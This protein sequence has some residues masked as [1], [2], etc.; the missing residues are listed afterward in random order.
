MD[1]HDREGHF[2]EVRLASI[3]EKLIGLPRERQVFICEVL[4]SFLR[5]E[6]QKDRWL[7]DPT[8][9]GKVEELA[10]LVQV[11]PAD[12]QDVLIRMLEIMAEQF[13]EGLDN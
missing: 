4:E 2:V 11:Q 8:D 3:F 13:R 1:L 6:G 10:D 9:E 12:R 7:S 5:V